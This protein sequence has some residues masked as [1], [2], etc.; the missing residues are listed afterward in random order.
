MTTKEVAI[1]ASLR[2][3]K[4]DD[5]ESILADV[6]DKEGFRR[7]EQRTVLLYQDPILELSVDR[8]ND[9]FYLSG[10]YKAGIQEATSLLGKMVTAFTKRGV[11]V[12]I[13]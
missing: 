3:D 7:I 6:V 5:I 10:R 1:Y 13:D 8:N 12:S 9:S 11:V 2:C 4:L